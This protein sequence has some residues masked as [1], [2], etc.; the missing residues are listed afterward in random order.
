MG[1]S[2][3]NAPFRFKQFAIEQDKVAMKVGTD[4]VLVACWAD[5]SD[6][7]KVL[8]IGTGTGV[9][10]L[11]LAQR[12][13]IRADI[14]AIDVDENAVL[15][16]STNF[17]QSPWPSA[18]TILHESIQDF[19]K[20]QSMKYDL[21]I[22]NPPF[23][24]GG[25]LSEN[26]DKN[27]VRHTTKLPHG[28][29]LQAVDRL[30]AMDGRLVLILPYLQGLRFMEISTTYRLFPYKI[31]EVITRKDKP[32]ERVLIEFVRTPQAEIHST[33]CIHDRDDDSFANEYKAL[34]KD[35]YLNF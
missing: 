34:T 3:A 1:K 33:L 20:N 30:L 28:D 14:H 4:G 26:N 35:F 29:L 12:I 10:A 31:T 9:I 24:T 13:G 27:D 5:V 15:Q 7:T 18:F 23:F 6:T 21:I 16:A 2:T 19:S 22:S 32:V 8:D 25:M 11:I 17:K